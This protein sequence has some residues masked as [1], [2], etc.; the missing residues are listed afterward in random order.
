LELPA[1]APMLSRVRRMLGRWLRHQQLDETVVTEIIIAVSEACAN[2]VEHA[3][4][5]DE[6]TFRVTA[7]HT[8]GSIEV[9]VADDGQWRPARGEN[10]G[11]GLTIMQTAMDSFDAR[12]GDGGTEIVMSRRTSAAA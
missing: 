2:A 3:Y 9:V 8:D 10:R 5:I 4:G 12:A 1:Q 7:K 6:G 11:R